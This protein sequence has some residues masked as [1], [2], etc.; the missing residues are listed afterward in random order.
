MMKLRKLEVILILAT[1][2]SIVNIFKVQDK[3][4]QKKRDWTNP[5]VSLLNQPANKDFNQQDR[6]ISSIPFL[7]RERKN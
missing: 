2:L 7:D 4:V 5:N 3:S 6:D 1:L